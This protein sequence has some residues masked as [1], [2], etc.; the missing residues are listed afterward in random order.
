MEEN[1]KLSNPRM[2]EFDGI[3]ASDAYK[4]NSD[5]FTLRDHFAGLAMQGHM[6]SEYGVAVQCDYR[7]Q[8][9]LAEAFY[10]MADAMLEQRQIKNI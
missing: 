7:E 1:K 9:L 2:Q 8:K 4:A 5:H 3:Y 10:S 6:A